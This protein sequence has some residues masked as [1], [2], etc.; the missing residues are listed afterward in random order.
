M[1][2]DR[3]TKPRRIGRTPF[4]WPE[5]K[6][7]YESAP[8]M[9]SNDQNAPDAAA[10]L[11]EIAALLRNGQ[12]VALVGPAGRGKSALLRAVAAE[13]DLSGGLVTYLDG[14][15]LRATSV[16]DLFGWLAAGVCATLDARGLP[17]EPALDAAVAEPGRLPFELAVRRL[18]QRGLSIVLAIDSFEHLCAS[19]QATIQFF[20]ALRSAAGRFRLVFLTASTRPLFDLTYANASEHILSSPFFNIFAQIWLR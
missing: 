6:W 10:A 12:S 19:P 8:L 7:E 14:A 1:V 9:S 4:G 16:P 17:S 18:N 2:W 5:Q 3:S 20:N 15:T 11:A 13:F